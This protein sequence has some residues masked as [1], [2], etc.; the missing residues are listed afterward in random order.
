[1][2]DLTKKLSEAAFFGKFSESDR[3]A[4]AELAIP[5]RLPAGEYCCYQGGYMAQCHISL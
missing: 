5:R 1:M 4:L 2:R 3:V